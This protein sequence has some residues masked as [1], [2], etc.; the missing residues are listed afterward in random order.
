LSFVSKCLQERAWAF[1][2]WEEIER[3]RRERGLQSLVVPFLRAF[4]RAI[5]EN[6]PFEASQ[7]TRWRYLIEFEAA[8]TDESGPTAADFGPAMA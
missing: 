1:P 3:S 8:A 4:V 5:K 7:R 2:F 6:G